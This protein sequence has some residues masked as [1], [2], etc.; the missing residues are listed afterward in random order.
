MSTRTNGSSTETPR[1]TGMTR[2]YG[3]EEPTYAGAGWVVF[4]SSMFVIAATLNIIWGLAA[5]ANSHFFVANA[6]FISATSTPGA[7]SRWGS[8]LSSS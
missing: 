3:T 2:E 7:G 4:A 5:V 1:T 6:S 8:G